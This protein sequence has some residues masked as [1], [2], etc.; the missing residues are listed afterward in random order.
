M[1]SFTFTKP[2]D[3]FGQKVYLDVDA[4]PEDDNPRNLAIAQRHSNSKDVSKSFVARN[5]GVNGID[6]PVATL[7]LAGGKEAQNQATP[8][9][10]A[11]FKDDIEGQ[12]TN[13]KTRKHDVK[14]T[15]VKKKTSRVVNR[16]RMKVNMLE[17]KIF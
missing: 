12:K 1:K 3:L 14:T 16:D 6:N 8:E 13:S 17:D 9:M 11:R 2:R 5:I 7:D 10:T 15:S 4:D